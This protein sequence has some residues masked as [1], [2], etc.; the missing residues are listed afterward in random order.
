MIHYKSQELTPKVAYKFLTGSITPRPIA[1]VTTQNAAGE[2]VNAAPFSFFNVVASAIP[3][4][5][6]SVVR[7]NC[8]PKDTAQNILATKELVIHLVDETMVADM[9]QTAANLPAQ[10]SEIDVFNI[11]TVAS[12]T[13]AVPGIKAA[14]IRME[15]S[16]TSI[17]A[18]QKSC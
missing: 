18:S 14:P 1:W 17:R 8:K 2:T 3:L 4:V 13:V 12:Q 16:L 11:E 7:T 5:T 6:I 9:N 15:S 10:S